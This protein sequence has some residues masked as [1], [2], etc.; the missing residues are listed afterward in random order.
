MTEH[1]LEVLQF[2]RIREI[3]ASY[4]VTD[5]G[6]EFCLKKNPDTDIKKIEEEKKLGI[7]F[8][9]LLRAYKAPP[10]KY[11]PPVLPFLEGIEV[12]GSALDIEGVYSVGLLA[13]SV[14]S[15]HEWLSSFLENED[16]NENSIIS[17]VKKI[18]DMLHLKNLVFSF[19][20]ENGELQ[21][22]PSLRAI[23]NKIRSIEDDIDKTM[24]N[25]FTNDATRQMLQSNLP[26]VKDGR[27][28][29]AVRSNFKGRIPGII[30]EY[31]QSGQTFYLEPE[32]I[33]LKN[34]DLIAAHAEY[35]RELLRLLQ[36]LTSQIAEH[37]ENIKEACEAITKLDCVA[38]ASRWAH[39][40]NCVFAGSIDLNLSHS[41][42]KDG[43]H[44]SKGSP[45]AF[46][47]HQARH[48]LLG[49]SA[50][51]IDLKLSKDDRALIITGPNTGG[52]TVSL[53]T[54][55]LFA[56]I[57]QTGWPVPAGP[58]TRL[59]YFD[60]I[61][62]DIGDE[63]SMDQSLSTFSA[64]MKN[65]SEII[66]RAG[67]KSLIILDELGS[68]T[69][70]QEGC[71]IAMAVL[72]D[73]L[74]KK[75]FVFVTTHHGALKNYGYSKESCVNASVEFNQ[76][77]LSPTY[78]ILMGV[79]GESHAVD[80]AKRNGLPEHIIEKAHT[81]LGNNRADVSD[82]IKGLIQKHEDLNEFELQKKEEELKLKEDRRRSDLKELQLKQK[83]L[84]LKK[85]GIKR[86]DLFFEEKRKFLENLVR[87]LREGELSREKTLSVKKWIDDFEKDLGKEHEA[88]KLEQTKIDERLHSSKEKNKAPQNP[89]LREGTRV[90]I[91]SL[92]RNGELIREE[93]KGKWLVAIDNL[94]LTIAEDDMEICEN[95]EKL[96]LSKPL[97]SIISD[98]SAPSSRPSFE[99]RLLGMRAEE[100][101]KAL[102]DQMDLALVHGITEFA[103]IHGKGHG[104]LQ[105]LSHD[106]LKRSPYV[107]AFRFA[108][109][110]E[111]GSGKTI[112]SLG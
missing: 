77:T 112:V 16:L 74:E 72:D 28:V 60:F 98:T 61:A 9:S 51:P 22:L 62:C 10:I 110:E 13:L 108:K 48:P 107:K 100:A 86:L 45:L 63:Q 69:D 3:I 101:Q 78:R 33:V 43:S 81:Y 30:H 23:K 1:T 2:S 106:F 14:F 73:L 89:E 58:L 53:K 68:G 90:I 57:N 27:Q 4:C 31:S 93:K 21:D 50:V 44:D 40:N 25:Y 66:R 49:K 17:F 55:A 92:N 85:D 76:N 109:P 41:I 71:A 20:D 15:L 8:L 64:H 7:D 56:L 96:K 36:D 70:P 79:P 24:R 46:Y 29:I 38:A 42:D 88:L 75:A 47:L 54:A 19:I 80:I 91:K 11:R 6:K 67:D 32:E 104:I 39:S 35:E 84:E 111:G 34:N 26:T 59:P 83:E 37:T 52:K 65:V 95:Q 105:E 102:Q 12:E 97:V 5:E 18:P 103:I 82:L 94:K 99:L 87:E